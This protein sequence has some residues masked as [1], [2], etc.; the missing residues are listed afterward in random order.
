MS[1][2]KLSNITKLSDVEKSLKNTKFNTFAKR[3]KNAHSELDSPIIESKF[4]RMVDNLIEEGDDHDP[5][6]RIGTGPA[7]P[8]YREMVPSVAADHDDK[9][10][11]E[12]YEVCD[13]EDLESLGLGDADT[14]EEKENHEDEEH[15]DEFVTKADLD[16]AIES[17]FDR[18]FNN[19]MRGKNEKLTGSEKFE[20]MENR[21]LLAK[22]AGQVEEDEEQVAEGIYSVLDVQD[23][24]DD[25]GKITPKEDNEDHADEEEDYEN[26]EECDCEGEED[27]DCDK[28][29]RKELEELEDLVAESAQEK[30]EP[31]ASIIRAAQH[32]FRQEKTA[33]IKE[34]TRQDAVATNRGIADAYQVAKSNDPGCVD[35]YKPLN[36]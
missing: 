33:V 12:D 30:F 9:V 21:D 29:A 1:N 22:V 34:S 2:K 5:N 27:C 10:N 32:Y 26:E 23:Q 16:D 28:V 4:D 36:G 35:G 15:K 7:K 25:K 17:A 31:Q 3:L 8:F 6:S 24:Q 14:D 20:D 18:L 11:P 13:E 19:A